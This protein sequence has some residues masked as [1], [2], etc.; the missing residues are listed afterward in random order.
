MPVV[1]ELDGVRIMLYAN[2]HPPPHFHA[3][4]A[5]HRAVID[6]ETLTVTEGF[7]PV[8]KR[9]KVLRWAATRQDALRRAFIQATSQEKVEPIA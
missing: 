9:K 4:F 6:I 3:W 7:L 8:A 1:A 2:E 5:E